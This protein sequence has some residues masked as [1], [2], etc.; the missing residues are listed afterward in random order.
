MSRL[1]LAAA[2]VA[3][4]HALPAIGVWVKG[5]RP[6]GGGTTKGAARPAGMTASADAQMRV[7]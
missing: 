2:T 7:Q 4:T 6:G 3:G 5:D 1:S